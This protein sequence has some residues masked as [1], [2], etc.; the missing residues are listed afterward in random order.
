MPLD[1]AG[2]WHASSTWHDSYIRDMTH[3]SAIVCTLNMQVYLRDMTRIYVTWLIIVPSYALWICNSIYVTWLMYMWHDSLQCPL[4]HFEYAGL[5]TWHGDM[6]HYSAL[7]CT[8][9]MQ[10]YLH[11]VTHIYVTFEYAGVWHDSSIC[12]MTHI[13]V[14]WLI[15]VHSYASWI[16]RS[17]YISWLMHM[18]HDSL[19]CPRTP[20]DYAG[21]WHDSSTWDDS[22]I[23]DMTNLYVIWYMTK[24]RHD[25]FS[26]VMTHFHVMYIWAMSCIYESC[27]VS[28][29]NMWYDTWLN[30]DM[31]RFHESCYNSFSCHI[32]MSH[33]ICIYDNHVTD[34]IWMCDMIH[35]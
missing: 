32:R 5:F 9:S 1:Y 28:H 24:R 18:W 23:Y 21:V 17:I 27:H 12:D 16:C 25:S 19:Q 14:T 20:L 11:D 15:I 29:V 10:V 31:T 26:W 6:T 7:V 35:N 13:Y 34:Q 22:Y 30:E 2:V 4:I 8:L 33:V 3:Y